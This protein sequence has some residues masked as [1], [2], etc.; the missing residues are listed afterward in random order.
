MLIFERN[1][2]HTLQAILPCNQ[3]YEPINI[4]LLSMTLI[5]M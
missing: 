1:L 4:F 3:L 5:F 2:I